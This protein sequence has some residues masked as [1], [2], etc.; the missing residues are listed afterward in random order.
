MDRPANAQRI[1]D[2]RIAHGLTL[3]ELARRIGVSKESVRLWETGKGLRGPNIFKLAREFGVDPSELCAAPDGLD[4]EEWDTDPYPTRQQFLIEHGEQ[5]AP[6]EV[7]HLLRQRYR[8]DPGELHWAD[9]L[10]RYRKVNARIE[11]SLDAKLERAK[12]IVRSRLAAA[13]AVP[14]RVRSATKPLTMERAT[15]VLRRHVDAKAKRGR[16]TEADGQRAKKS[17][18]HK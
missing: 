9:E 11:A 15:E 4:Q 10:L 18:K 13:S 1:R 7:D 17:N 3:E 12:E 8:G 6:D 16:G 14:A 2:L 5:L